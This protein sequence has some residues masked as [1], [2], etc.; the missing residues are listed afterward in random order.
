[1]GVESGTAVAARASASAVPTGLARAD[2]SEGSSLRVLPA[3]A[4]KSKP[5]PS[6][7]R[8][9]VGNSSRPKKKIRT[10]A[11]T[12]STAPSPA[13]AAAAPPA[14]PLPP[15]PGEAIPAADATDANGARARGLVARAGSMDEYRAGCQR[16][17][18]ER[19]EK[20]YEAEKRRLYQERA[21]DTTFETQV[22]EAE[23]AYASGVRSLMGRLLQEN[24]DRIKR[25]EE[26]RFGIIRD[27]EAPNG[28]RHEMSLRGRTHN[29]DDATI[30]RGG[31]G[32][33]DDD[34][35]RPNRRSRK[36]DGRAAANHPKVKLHLALDA[37][38]VASDMAKITGAKRSRDGETS[39]ER[40]PKK[41]K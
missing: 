8:A 24:A 12:V 3:P 36:G 40:R 25:F 41:R 4:A 20:I 16:L 14:A 5:K 28:R 38:D 34:D 13:I 27:D 23:A 1:M 32:H 19:H 2:G 22:R 10:S 39:N 29:D 37:A 35:G 15:I 11:P 33:V 30:R 17:E 31:N 26:I 21:I 18:K 6:G 7:S 9:R